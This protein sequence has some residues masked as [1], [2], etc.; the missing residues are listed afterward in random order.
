[1]QILSFLVFYKKSNID[2]QRKC[3]VM[4]ILQINEVDK[5]TEKYRVSQK[6]KKTRLSEKTFFIKVLFD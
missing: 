6:M 2:Y 5:S 3:V 1:M 4:C